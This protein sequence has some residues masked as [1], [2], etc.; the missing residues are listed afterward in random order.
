[1]Y[2]AV[3][4]EIL[5]IILPLLLGVAF[6]VLAERKVMAFVQRRKGPDVVGSF[7][8]LQPLADGLKLILKEPIS[9]S[10]ANFSLF[11]MAP[12]A[13]FM[14]SLV[15]RAV[16]PFDYGMV[17]SDSNIGLLYLFAISSLGVYGI[18]TAGWSSNSKYAFLGAL[19]SAAQMVSY[20]V[21]IGLILITV[22]I[23][24]GPRNSSEI[25]MAQKQI[26]SGIPLFPVLVMFFISRLA[27][28]NRAPFDLPEAEAE[29]V[30]GYNVEYSSMGSALF[31]LGEYANM[32]LMS[33]PCT[34]LSPGGWPPILD[35]PIFKRIPGSIWFSIKVILFLFLYI[36]V[37][38]AFPRYR[39][40]Q[41][42]GLGRKVFLPLSLAR[43]VAV[44]GVSVTFP[45]LP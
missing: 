21:S 6:L 19:R 25:V 28:T 23:C 34:S 1:M 43:V 39:Y 27:E 3:P 33:G 18:I 41:L 5:G 44:S 17:L 16:V 8:L 38:A 7:G 37:R 11:R 31:F 10:S 24:V 36:W 30:A 4:A 32:I 9:P 42:M 29:S 14:L 22:L 45:W 15:A 2:I 13:T 26:W 20:E 35:L 40:D 12:V